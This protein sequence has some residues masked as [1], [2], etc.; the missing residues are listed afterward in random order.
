MDNEGCST[1]K[2]GQLVLLHTVETH[3]GV[4]TSDAH[5]DMY[6]CRYR[7]AQHFGH[8]MTGDH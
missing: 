8:I 5:L 1:C 4:H 3:E 2:H 7:R 6:I